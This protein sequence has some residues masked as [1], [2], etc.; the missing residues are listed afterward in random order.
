MAFDVDHPHV[1][2][3]RVIF[4]LVPWKG[5]SGGLFFRYIHVHFRRLAVQ[6]ERFLA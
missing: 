3:L 5:A 1:I 4:S 6:S 2:N